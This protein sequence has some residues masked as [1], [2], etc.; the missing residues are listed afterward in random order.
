MLFYQAETTCG[1][2]AGKPQDYNEPV[3]KQFA[4]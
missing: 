3:L 4:I 2:F 1:N